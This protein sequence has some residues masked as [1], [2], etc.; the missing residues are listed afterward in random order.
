MN[1]KEK[2]IYFD[3]FEKAQG[4]S[5]EERKAAADAAVKAYRNPP[6]QAKKTIAQRRIDTI[7]QAVDEGVRQGNKANR[8][9]S[10]KQ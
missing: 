2:K 1:S 3:A 9:K 8:V 6:K 10:K 4:K 5:Y 7:N